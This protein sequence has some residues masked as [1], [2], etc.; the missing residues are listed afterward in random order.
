MWNVGSSVDIRVIPDIPQAAQRLQTVSQVQQGSFLRA[1][2]EKPAL[3]PSLLGQ[4]G[5]ML[6]S[7]LSRQ[8]LEDT[9][10]WASGAGC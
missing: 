9:R 5:G 10:S 6:S 3:L 2:P 7:M 1:R 4:H 8:R